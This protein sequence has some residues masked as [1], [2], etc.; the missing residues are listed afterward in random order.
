M[1]RGKGEEC[2]ENF[3]VHLCFLITKICRRRTWTISGGK[4]LIHAD[5]FA[6]SR[7]EI[8]FYDG[9]IKFFS[10]SL[11]E[12]YCI[13]QNFSFCVSYI[14]GYSFRPTP[15][16]QLFP[17]AAKVYCH[18]NR[19]CK[20]F[21]IILFEAPEWKRISCWLKSF[22]SSQFEGSRDGQLTKVL[23]YWRQSEW[24]LSKLSEKKVIFVEFLYWVTSTITL[25]RFDLFSIFS[26]I[27]VAKWVSEYVASCP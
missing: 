25:R 24:N 11:L 2:Q 27:V 21:K 3:T 9:K 23:Y 1:K 14:E 10:F 19:F 4:N 15:K 12:F 5:V 20:N 18:W 17:W 16:A 13:K 6:F 26:R 8:H 22:L 7:I